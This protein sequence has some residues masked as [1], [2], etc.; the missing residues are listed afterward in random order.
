M[1]RRRRVV[2]TEEALRSLEQTLDY[3]ALDSEANA[4]RVGA[5]FLRAVRLIARFPQLG[6]VVP[7][8]GDPRLR[9]RSVFRFRLIYRLRGE[10]LEV[11]TI[12]HA[13]SRLPPRRAE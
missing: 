11:V 5:E 12:I 8:V 7:E 13:A 1:A 3:V 2:W 4:R 10:Q 6:R 9:E